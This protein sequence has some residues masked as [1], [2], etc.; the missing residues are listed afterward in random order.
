MDDVEISNLSLTRELGSGYEIIS[1]TGA[2][3]ARI[4]QN[5]NGA[6]HASLAIVGSHGATQLEWGAG[7]DEFVEN[8]KA[9]L[10]NHYAGPREAQ[11]NADYYAALTGD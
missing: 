3:I 7:Y 11:Q 5:P 8:I 9:A 10:R 2:V 6:A 4:T 1:P